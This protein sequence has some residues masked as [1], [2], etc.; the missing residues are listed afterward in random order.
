M[1]VVETTYVHRLDC[2]PLPFIP[3]R[4]P[5]D[6]LTVPRKIEGGRGNG[7]RNRRFGP[8]SCFRGK[9]FSYCFLR[10]ASRIS[11]FVALGFLDRMPAIRF[12]VK[13]AEMEVPA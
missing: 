6:V 2:F 8:L 11:C 3:S 12:A 1:G 9:D 13:A 7:L 5:F 4:Q 10:R